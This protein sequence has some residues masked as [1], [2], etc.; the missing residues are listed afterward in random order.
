[1]SAT[2]AS[3]HVKALE[4]RLG[5]RLLH[6]TTRRHSLTEIGK[7]FYEQCVDILARIDNAETTAREMRSQPRGRLRVSAP[8][9]L[10]SHML[11]PALS[12]YLK[13]YREV[14]IELTLND[15][16]VDLVEEGFDVAFR[17][18]N[19][20]DS[21]LVARPLRTLSRVVCASPAY[22]AEHGTPRS[23]IE[24]ATHNCLAFQYI[25]PERAWRFDEPKSQTVTV[26]GQLTVNNGPALLMA[27]LN[28]V[29]IVML[30]EF[31]VAN[32]VEAGR[33]V[34]LFPE[35]NFSRAPL[36]LVY[37]PDRHMT[38]KLKSFVDFVVER[39]G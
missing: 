14:E 5:A 35:Q 30:P 33:L 28:G 37:L 31:L 10:G 12:D 19:L 9:T 13:E 39:F 7:A 27:A 4:L 23:A 32:D 16:V 6:R 26:S 38:P 11:V 8:V 29:G 2:M 20:P 36:Q 24:L 21:G 34:R 3:N 22:L 25:Q 15:R 18:G 17:F 1:M